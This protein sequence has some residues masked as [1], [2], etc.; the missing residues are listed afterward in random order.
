MSSKRTEN[1]PASGQ[2]RSS[3][4]PGLPR[5]T[6]RVEGERGYLYDRRDHQYRALNAGECFLLAEGRQRPLSALA[7]LLA[8]VGR[9]QRAAADLARVRRLTGTA[10]GSRLRAELVELTPVPGAAAAPLVVHLG[11]TQACNFACAHCY[12]SSGRRADDELTAGELRALVDELAAIGCCKLVV[13]GGEPFLRRELVGLVESAQRCGVDCFVHTNGSRLRPATLSRLAR[14]APAALV[15]SLD[16]PDA[17]SNDRMRGAGSFEK[18]RR[19]LALLRAH[20]PPGFAISFTVTPTN[21]NLAGDMVELAK[22][23]GARLLL[24][25]PAYPAGAALRA[26]SDMACNRDQFA[27]AVEQAR[28]ANRRGHLLLDAPHTEERTPPDFEGFGCVAGR[29]VA[30]ITPSGRVTPCL[31][32]PGRFAAGSL[33]QR[34]LLELWR[35]GASFVALRALQPAGDC[36]RCAR[37][38]VCRGGCRVRALARHRRVDAPDAWCSFEPLPRYRS[39]RL[40]RRAGNATISVETSA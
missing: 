40:R 12:S 16:G 7:P 11:L 34:S 35:E 32:L 14:A 25:R 23:E 22:R 39:G 2:R 15:V 24:L 9:P 27:A 38:P 33:R 26:G 5:L 29:L 4:D 20:Y 30:G 19:G 1:E 36:G 17:P 6:V 28:R 18:T 3:A 21:Y 31:N 8:A 37:Y 13:G 10:E